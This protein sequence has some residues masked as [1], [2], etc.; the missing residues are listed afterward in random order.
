MLDFMQD[1]AD[2]VV[3]DTTQLHKGMHTGV[4]IELIGVCIASVNVCVSI[5]QYNVNYTVYPVIVTYAEF[6]RLF[7]D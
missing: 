2:E 3:I 1:D 7:V 5:D 6:I 4:C